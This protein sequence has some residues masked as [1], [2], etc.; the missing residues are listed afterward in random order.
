MDF[1]LRMR[2]PLR[3]F[4]KKANYSRGLHLHTQLGQIFVDTGRMFVNPGLMTVSSLRLLDQ[5]GEL[6]RLGILEDRSP[7]FSR[8]RHELVSAG[9]ECLRVPDSPVRQPFRSSGWS[10]RNLEECI[11]TILG[12]AI[13]FEPHFA[14]DFVPLQAIMTQAGRRVP[15]IIEKVSPE[16]AIP[17]V[18]G[19]NRKLLEEH[20]IFTSHPDM[21]VPVFL[22]RTWDGHARA[23]AV[24]LLH[25]ENGTKTLYCSRDI[26]FGRRHP[27][28]L[29][30]VGPAMV[31][32]RLLYM[33]QRGFWNDRAPVLKDFFPFILDHY[34]SFFPLT[35]LR[36][37]R[38]D[39]TSIHCIEA[40]L[41]LSSTYFEMVELH[42]LARRPT[43]S[44]RS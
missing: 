9:Y 27:D 43:S 37:M 8:V 19:A 33:K 3:F 7:D 21:E 28:A 16:E 1:S 5:L 41:I 4:P 26:K 23:M 14:P 15:V 24:C 12:K 25:P 40:E 44:A 17:L 29:Q 20:R 31:I 36:R 18:R 6:Q 32:A 35:A 2:S 34:R 11:Q 10:G 38:L 22:M 30:N 42:P 13:Q 39:P